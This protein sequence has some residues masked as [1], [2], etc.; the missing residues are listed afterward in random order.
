LNICGA[1]IDC[2]KEKIFTKFNG[3]SYEFNFSKFAK[4][5][6]G[7]DM[8]DENFRVEQ[9]A[10]IALAPNNALQKFMEDHESDVF[11]KEREEIDDI[12]LRQQPL[13]KHN[14]PMEDLGTTL[15]PKEDPIFELKPLPDDLKYAYIDDKKI[16]PVIISSKF[17]GKEEERLLEILR[18]HRGAMG[19]TLDDL[20]GICPHFM[21]ACY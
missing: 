7:N 15:P 5:T 2:K 16:Y 19:Y 17:S 4:T 21:S 1:V 18:K 10:S 6:Y 14:L 12:F 20:K 3:E 8:P 13:I 9:L 11:R